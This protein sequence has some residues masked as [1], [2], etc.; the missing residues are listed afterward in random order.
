MAAVGSES[1]LDDRYNLVV[2]LREYRVSSLL[3]CRAYPEYFDSVVGT[4]LVLLL[5]TPDWFRDQIL[6]ET[7]VAGQADYI[8]CSTTPDGRVTL[9]MHELGQKPVIKQV[10]LRGLRVD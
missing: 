5:K 10:T 4:R 3:V 9:K 6:E 7:G 1:T 2:P 8:W